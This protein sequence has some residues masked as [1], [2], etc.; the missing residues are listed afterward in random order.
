[1]S[2]A[3]LDVVSLALGSLLLVAPGRSQFLYVANGGGSNNVSA[4]KIDSQG[5]LIPLP[6]SPFKAGNLPSSAVTA[7]G[8]FAYVVNESS[9]NV[10]AYKIDSDGTLAAVS[11]SPFPVGND[12]HQLVVDPTDKFAYVALLPVAGSPFPAG[13]G[14][15]SVA[16]K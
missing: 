14:P 9:S 5:T 4:Y 15:N 6:G 2:R 10:T 13:A 3:C 11:G 1:M 8:D 7:N 16:L 12:P